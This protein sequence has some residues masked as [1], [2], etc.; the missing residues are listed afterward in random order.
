MIIVVYFTFFVATKAG[1]GVQ[2]DV[3]R[4]TSISST[5]TSFAGNYVINLLNEVYKQI[6]IGVHNEIRVL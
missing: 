4:E 3:R 6:L 1:I 2:I 5:N